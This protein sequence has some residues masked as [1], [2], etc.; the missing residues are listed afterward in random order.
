MKSQLFRFLVI[1][2][3][4][5][6]IVQTVS[7]CLAEEKAQSNNILTIM[8]STTSSGD[9]PKIKGY[10][11]Y[12]KD[13]QDIR[14]EI[15]RVGGYGWNFFGEYIKELKVQMIGGDGTYQISIRENRVTV[16]ES[17]QI[18]TSDPVVYKKK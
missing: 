11:I 6:F 1:S 10:Y 5:M 13:G 12:V 9:H 7:V 17:E 18:S 14:E 2:I 4:L 8:L 15:E 3:G 16:F